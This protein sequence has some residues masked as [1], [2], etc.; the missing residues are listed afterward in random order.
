MIRWV[1]V[2]GALTGLSGVMAGAFGAHG[3]QGQFAPRA[4]EVYET[5]VTYQIYHAFSLLAVAILSGLGLSRRILL[6]SAC[7]F[8]VGVLLFSGSLYG[9]ALLQWRFLGPVTPV[10]G[11]CLMVGWLL[12]AAAGLHTGKTSVPEQ[13]TGNSNR[14]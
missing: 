13:Q 10:G 9:L 5:A 3:L 7:F 6:I 4:L 8:V 11:L 14:G 12:L 1:L 2:A